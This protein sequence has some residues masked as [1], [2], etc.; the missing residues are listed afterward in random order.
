MAAILGLTIYQLLNV[1]QCSTLQ[2]GP[3][4]RVFSKGHVSSFSEQTMGIF[5][6]LCYHMKYVINEVTEEGKCCVR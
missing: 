6:E 4:D 5:A 2:F 3:S 1:Y